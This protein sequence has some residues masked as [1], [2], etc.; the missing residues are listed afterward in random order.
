MHC[1]YC[2]NEFDVNSLTEEHVVPASLGGPKFLVLKNAACEECNTKKMNKLDSFLADNFPPTKMARAELDI[3]SPHSGEKPSFS[4][5][6]NDPVIGKV[7]FNFEKPLPSDG[8]YFKAKKHI[9]KDGDKLFCTAST[10]EEGLKHLSK[11]MKRRITINDID[12]SASIS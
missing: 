7:D 8:S 6:G 5:I 9:K 11:K 1:I 4:M 10:M 2:E 12:D 3:R